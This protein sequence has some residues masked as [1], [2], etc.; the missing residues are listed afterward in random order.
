MSLRPARA[1]AGLAGLA[2]LLIYPSRKAA[3]ARAMRAEIALIEDDRAAL[4][5]ALGCLWGGCRLRLAAPLS[6]IDEGAEIMVETVRN[7]G[8]PRSLGVL[9]ALAATGL[10]LV[11]L[12]AAGAPTR[13]LVVNAV[14]F[15][16]GIVALRGLAGI[17]GRPARWSGRLIA[18]LSLG[19][20]ATALLGTPVEGAARWIW[21]GPLSVQLSLVLLPLMVV[22]F[23]RTPDRLGAAGLVLAAAAL[24]LQPDRAMAGALAFAL[25]TLAIQRPRAD[26]IVPALAAAAGFAFAAARPDAL[27]AVPYVDHILYTAFGIHALLG[28]AVLLGAALLLVPAVAGAWR[29]PTGRPA[30][31]AF[32][33]LWFGCILA[34]ALGNYPTPVVGYGGSAILGYLLSLA[35]LLPVQAS[36]SAGDGAT[37]E[38]DRDG[39]AGP[40]RM[41]LAVG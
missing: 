9:C 2:L 6:S 13:T 39:Q 12:L 24:A 37:A 36:A 41:R 7:L 38:A 31:I 8:Q 19:L 21:I 5:F 14:A 34:A 10:G 15:L 28:A 25:S 18:A 23:A 27:P 16:L 3:W 4:R 26:T 35:F 29:D 1:L 22:A 30:H 40:G 32:G 11:Y 17:A 20:L 33:A